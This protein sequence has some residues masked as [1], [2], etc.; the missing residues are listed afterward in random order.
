MADAAILGLRL[1]EGLEV[2]AFEQNYGTEL[3]K[4]Y[5]DVL[6]E[7]TEAGLLER[8]NGALRLTPRGRL[9]ANEVFV[10]LLPD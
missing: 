4:A 7:M 5:G 9:L 8:V 2:A 6:A 3:D 10:R 1:N